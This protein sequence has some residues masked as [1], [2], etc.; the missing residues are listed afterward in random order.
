MTFGFFVY[1]DLSELLHT[2][3]FHDCDERYVRLSK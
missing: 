1:P 3:G 2:N